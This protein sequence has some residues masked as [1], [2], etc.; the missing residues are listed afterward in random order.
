MPAWR[1]VPAL[2]EDVWDNVWAYASTE[3]LNRAIA[4][5]Q[6]RETLLQ[7]ED[8][9]AAGAPR[10]LSADAASAREMEKLAQRLVL[11]ARAELQSGRAS[12]PGW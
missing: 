7:R 4:L 3:V 1:L 5:S 6:L 11:K 2:D 12:Q 9:R 10:S 8:E